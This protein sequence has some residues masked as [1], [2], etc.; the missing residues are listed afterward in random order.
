[1]PP[2]EKAPPSDPPAGNP[3]RG[4]DARSSEPLT[5]AAVRRAARA[6]QWAEIVDG[7]CAMP[8]DR[9][10]DLFVRL[11]APDQAMLLRS[12]S[13]AL[14]ATLLMDCDRAV[15][16]R[17]LEEIDPA[18]IAFA[19]HL[20]PPEQLAEILPRLAEPAARRVLDTLDPSLRDAVRA[21]TVFDPQSASGLMTTHYLSVPEVFS[22]SRALELL[23]KAEPSEA[24]SYIYVVD[25]NGRL[26]GTAPVRALLFADAR[27]PVGSV[28]RKDPVRLK[29]SDPVDEVIRLF[30]R[31]HF[32][33]LPVTDDTGRLLGIVT[34]DDVLGAVRRAEDEVVRGV[35]GADPREALKATLAATR[36]RLP[37]MVSTILGGLACAGLGVLFQEVMREFIVLALFL[38]IVLAAAE[39]VAAQTVSVVLSALA[40]GEIPRGRIGAFVAKEMGIGLL[41]GL[42]T[43]SSVAALSLIWHGS[44]RIGV[45]IGAAI[46][47]SVAWAAFL[48][49]SIPLAL[50]R[51]QVNPAVASGPLTLALSDLA[52]LTF[53]LGGAAVWLPAA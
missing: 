1:M 15:L 26:T 17:P 46:T 32:L 9:R 52:T 10:L 11:T 43:G 53:Y 3:E 40:A 16:K 7:F 42:F 22:V 21:R 18:D 35:T 27:Q 5:P 33:A 49:V 34:S 39:S 38:T 29:A 2:D 28:A 20:V 36:G 13:P 12:V 23:R 25:A 31:F 14:A 47:A 30:N 8:A 41:L 6:G 45:L 44:P 50:R 4:P 24:P 19:L 51:L 37:W 48:G